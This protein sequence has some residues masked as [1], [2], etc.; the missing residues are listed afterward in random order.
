[1]RLKKFMFFSIDNNSLEIA[2]FDTLKTLTG[3]LAEPGLR[4]FAVDKNLA[5]QR[6]FIMSA[7]IEVS[8]PAFPLL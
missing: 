1:M 5:A 8:Y 2:R 6:W 4:L 7:W 3:T